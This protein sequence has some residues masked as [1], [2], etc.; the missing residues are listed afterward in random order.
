MVKFHSGDQA[1]IN[2]YFLICLISLCTGIIFYVY[3]I[4]V[5]IIVQIIVLGILFVLKRR[6]VF[7]IAVIVMLTGLLITGQ[8]LNLSDNVLFNY[9]DKESKGTFCVTDITYQSSYY[10][11]CTAKITEIENTECNENIK[12]Y[13]YTKD[14]I[15]DNGIYNFRNMKLEMCDKK[16]I[17]SYGRNKIFFCGNISDEDI[18]F[19]GLAEKGIVNKI[20]NLQIKTNEYI[21]SIFSKD[22]AALICALYTGEKKYISDYHNGIFS[23]TGISHILSVSG[24]HVVILMSVFGMFFDRLGKFRYLKYL[25][26]LAFVVFTGASPAIIRAACLYTFAGIGQII[27]RS[28]DSVNNLSFIALASLLLNPLLLFDKS[29]QLSYIAT[30]A[31]IAVSPLFHIKG[32]NKFFDFFSSAVSITLAAQIMTLPITL[33]FTQEVT[34]VSL[35][36]NAAAS[37]FTLIIYPVSCFSM[38]LPFS[39]VTGL[40]EISVSL[41]YWVIETL[42]K[43]DIFSFEFVNRHTA[44]IVASI[45]SVLLFFITV[46][47]KNRVIRNELLKQKDITE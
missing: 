6:N 5:L 21:N 7:L 18:N 27:K 43:G 26:L 29:F 30:Y 9:T 25:I 14:T 32:S 17:L 37:L 40:S 3:E 35:S 44:I 22:T 11:S 46:E 4:N 15:H 38:L 1:L 28:C 39:F 41:L 31:V 45:I 2:R 20:K 19:K 12:L 33:T 13:I 36:A 10:V 23:E 42:S 47:R 34:L 16:E 8:Y 24:M